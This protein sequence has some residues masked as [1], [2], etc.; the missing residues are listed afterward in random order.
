MREI[1]AIKRRIGFIGGGNMGAALLAGLL[2]RGVAAD[3]IQVA[4]K[5]EERASFLATEYG[6]T[7]VDSINGLKDIE[8]MI[9]AVKP[10]DIAACVA[11]AKGS[12]KSGAMVISIAAGVRI[13]TVQK[14]LSAGTA[15]VR[16][17]PNTPALVGK[18]VTALAPGDAADEKHMN[19]ARRIFEAV[20]S[21]VE[22]S[23]AQMDAV[24]GLSGSGPA[25]IYMVIEALADAGVMQGLARPVALQLA[26]QTVAGAAE[27]VLQSGQ[28]PAVLKDQVTSP[29]GTTI[30]GVKTL[31]DHSLRAALMGA[32]A[33]ATNRSRELG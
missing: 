3:Q 17:M 22:V 33:T 18:G 8:V 27:M 13:A 5:V 6:V 11:Q 20:G 15:V 30:A 19:L 2:A 26:A 29:G 12:L 9:L 23:E 4:E 31:E 10:F 14:A 32:V 24:T 21:V 28:H 25:Y 1:M 16:A 7:V